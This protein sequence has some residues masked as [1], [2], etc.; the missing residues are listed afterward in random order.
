MKALL[1]RNGGVSVK[2]IARPALEA[3]DSV[4]IKVALT[5]ICRTDVYVA[6]DIIK[7]APEQDLVLGHE[8]AGTVEQ[9]GDAVQ[10]LKIG[11]R[12]CV[13]PFINSNYTQKE[14]FLQARMLGL[15]INGSFAEYIAVPR[16]TVFKL[17]DNVSFKLG[18]YMEP[19]AASMAV[20]NANIVPSQKGLIYGDNRI[21]RLTLRILEAKGFDT[22]DLIDIADDN[23]GMSDNSYDFIIETQAN[24]QT[25]KQMIDWVKPGGTIILKSRQHQPVEICV[26]DLVQKSI[27]LKAVSYSNFQEAID[28]V[29]SGTLQVDDLLGDVYPLE[30]YKRIFKQSQMGEAKKLFLSALPADQQE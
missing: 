15:H 14:N 8:F 3:E 24:S 4:L 16:E 7:T 2:N 27:T 6:E 30:D 9:C 18:A 23:V 13:F 5:G 21:S 25:I 29:A 17:P 19:I 12:V 1:K 28:L 10:D 26:N 20:L 11:E 22:V